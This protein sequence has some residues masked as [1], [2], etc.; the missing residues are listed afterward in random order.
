MIIDLLVIRTGK[1]LEQ[2]GKLIYNEE[3]LKAK[4][5]EF[6]D[7]LKE[8]ATDVLRGDFD[9]LPGIKERVTKRAKE[10][11]GER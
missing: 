2:D 8:H 4:T 1:K 10:L 11:E 5:Q 7:L 9:V 3:Y 6:A